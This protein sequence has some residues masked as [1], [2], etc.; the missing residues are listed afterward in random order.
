MP[1]IVVGNNF[2]R[3]F[4]V[5]ELTMELAKADRGWRGPGIRRISVV[6]LHGSP[7]AMAGEAITE[8]ARY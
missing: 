7:E 1:L 3:I 4:F 5:P 6:A 2:G 8:L